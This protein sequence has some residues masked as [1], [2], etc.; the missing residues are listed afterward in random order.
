MISLNLRCSNNH[1][2]EGLFPSRADFG[3][4]QERG[5]VTCPLCD[6]Q[7]IEPALSTPAVRNSQKEAMPAI[8]VKPTSANTLTPEQI[9][10]HLRALRNHVLETHEDM[11]PEFANEARRIHYGDA[12]ER[13]IMGQADTHEI[14]ELLDEGVDILPLPPQI[15]DDA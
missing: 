3:D 11:G 8:A 12:E 1:S 7:H 4:Q 14:R 15:K 9:R 2:F 5:L 6:S 13:G 10:M